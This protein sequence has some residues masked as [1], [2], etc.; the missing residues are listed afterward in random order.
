MA[1][2]T[3]ATIAIVGAGPLGLE[4]ALYARYL[5]YDVVIFER[6]LVGQHV[7]ELA[8]ARMAA[9]FGSS[10]SALGLAAL[11][12][13]DPTWQRPGEEDLLTAAEWL[14]RYLLRLASSDLLAPS[15]HQQTE[16]IDVR[17]ADEVAEEP[18]QT[19]P[20]RSPGLMDAAETLAEDEEWVTYVPLVVSA[21]DASGVALHVVAEAV[22]VTSQEFI[23]AKRLCGDE[24]SAQ[25]PSPPDEV[26]SLATLV[27]NVYL[28]GGRTTA[29]GR[30][31]EDGLR[32]IR[33]LFGLIGG[34]ESLDLYPD[35]PRSA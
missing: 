25:S 10:R 28:L 17:G 13:Q 33:A 9:P 6:G 29:G 19:T 34:R 1:I 16:V 8:D 35:L 5:G 27:P 26:S 24:V 14:E 11:L 4:A 32:Q 12:A 7:R 18:Q 15:I 2:D 23:K 30:S 3:P 21:R 20:G 22:I 31:F